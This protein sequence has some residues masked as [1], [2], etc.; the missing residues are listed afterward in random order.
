MKHSLLG[1]TDVLIASP[2]EASLL[3]CRVRDDALPKAQSTRITVRLS[4]SASF[5]GCL[6]PNSF[7]GGGLRSGKKIHITAITDQ[8]RKLI[9]PSYDREVVVQISREG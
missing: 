1:A 5:Y 7:I 6:L 9:H 8:K 3:A 2:A 4:L